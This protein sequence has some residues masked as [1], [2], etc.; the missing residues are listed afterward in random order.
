MKSCHR[1][2][3]RFRVVSPNCKLRLKKLNLRRIQW[4]SDAKQDF[5]D[6]V[7]AGYNSYHN[8]LSVDVA[9]KAIEE[10]DNNLYSVKKIVNDSKMFELKFSKNLTEVLVT[11]FHDT[12]R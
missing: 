2:G 3:E 10:E 7:G 12:F 4:T 9:E 1:T 11:I 5:E 8:Y 6:K